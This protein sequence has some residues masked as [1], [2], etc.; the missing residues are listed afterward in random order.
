MT[1]VTGDL[2]RRH[3][4]SSRPSIRRA[5]PSSTRPAATPAARG[6][7]SGQPRGGERGPIDGTGAQRVEQATP[8]LPIG[9][10]EHRL[11]AGGAGAAGGRVRPT[12]PC[13]R[14]HL[15]RGQRC[16][17]ASVT[18]TR[19]PP[20]RVRP[21]SRPTPSR[22]GRGRRPGPGPRPGASGAR[23]R[24]GRHSAGVGVQHTHV[25]AEGEGQDRPGRCRAR[26]RAGRAG[27]EDP[28]A[29]RH[30]GARRRRRRHGAGSG[31]G[32]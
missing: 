5:K 1:H 29:S 22:E 3:A 32:G 30:R 28:T 19:S 6:P 7:S 17:P 4:S 14:H 10:L 8:A 13:H 26:C 21:G 16:T 25:T 9:T 18:C 12:P 20:G 24:P 31:P 27:R 15:A 2:G 23:R 11:A